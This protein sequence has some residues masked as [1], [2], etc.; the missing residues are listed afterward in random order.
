MLCN[1]VQQSSIADT[2]TL[3]VF[4]TVM[5]AEALST[6]CFKLTFIGSVFFIILFNAVTFYCVQVQVSHKL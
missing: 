2:F 6:N 5:Y 3:C 1:D 4:N